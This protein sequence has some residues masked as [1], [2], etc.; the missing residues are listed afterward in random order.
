[1]LVI[2][3]ALAILA[4]PPSV[5]QSSDNSL[6][7]GTGTVIYAKCVDP[8]DC[9]Y[10]IH[11]DDNRNFQPI[12]LRST[13]SADRLRIRFTANLTGEFTVHGM[14]AIVLNSISLLGDLDGDLHVNFIDAY[15]LG[16]AFGSR[17]SSIGWNPNADL[18]YDN[19]VDILDALLLGGDYGARV[20]QFSLDINLG[21]NKT[22]YDLGEPVNVTLTVTNITNETAGFWLAPSWWDFLVY[23]DTNNCLYQW[24]HS[25]I[26]FP[27]WVMNV[28]LEP[29]MTVSEAMVWPQTCNATVD[30]YGTPVSPVSP[31]TYYIVGL[32]FHYDL[33]TAPVQINII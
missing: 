10:F 16:Q 21:L 31:G 19:V 33:Q 30:H 6:F 9:F 23:N 29:G 15:W 28:T 8:L 12:N 22:E 11:T 13:F 4:T 32:Y 14:E 25:G 2:G 26:V 17:P 24:S 7:Q 18:N 20:Q 27:M 3:L 5:V 1:M